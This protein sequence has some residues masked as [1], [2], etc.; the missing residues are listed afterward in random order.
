MNV[1][2]PSSL[3][4]VQTK[5]LFFILLT[6]SLENKQTERDTRSGPPRREVPPSAGAR[7]QSFPFSGSR[8]WLGKETLEPRSGS[9]SGPLAGQLSFQRYYAS[10]PRAG[11]DP[12]AAA[13]GGGGRAGGR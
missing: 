10:C 11:R 9:G 4:A 8:R 6:V 1:K 5:I 7:R 12:A 2:G 13:A 3:I